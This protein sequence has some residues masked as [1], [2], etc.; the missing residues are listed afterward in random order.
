MAKLRLNQNQ[1]RTLQA[2]AGGVAGTFLARLLGM[3]LGLLLIAALSTGAYVF[4]W[5]ILLVRKHDEDCPID[6]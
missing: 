1:T 6:M 4:G 2:F 5:R 3:P